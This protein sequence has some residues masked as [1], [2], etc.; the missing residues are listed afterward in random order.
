MGGRQKLRE[1]EGVGSIREHWDTY[2][3]PKP[4]TL[5]PRP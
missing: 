2:P 3:K 1:T 4:K 5:N